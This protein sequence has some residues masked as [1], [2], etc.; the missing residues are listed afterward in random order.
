MFSIG[1]QVLKHYKAKEEDRKKFD[2]ADDND[3]I[4]IDKNIEQARKNLKLTK[5]EK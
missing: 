4:D 5:P 1:E 2:R 3:R